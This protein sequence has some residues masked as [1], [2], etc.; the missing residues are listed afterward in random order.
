M[1]LPPHVALDWKT[2]YGTAACSTN[3]QVS[4]SEWTDDKLLTILLEQEVKNTA[5]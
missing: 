4:N 2:A 1:K 5:E 3:N